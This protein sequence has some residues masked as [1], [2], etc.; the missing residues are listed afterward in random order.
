MPD[1]RLDPA[2]KTDRPGL[3]YSEV[4]S[5]RAPALEAEG[6]GEAALGSPRWPV[7]QVP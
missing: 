4:L 2:P 5:Q 3:G 1:G 6:N 7:K